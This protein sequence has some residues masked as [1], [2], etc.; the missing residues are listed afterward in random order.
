MDNLEAYLQPILHFF[1]N[2]P[3]LQ[4]GAVFLITFF[5]A[6][7]VSWIIFRVLKVLTSKTESYLDDRLLAIARP[8]IYYSLVITG[9]STAVKI[10]PIADSLSDKLIFG[11]KTI[12]VFIWMIALIRVSKIILQQLA[13]SNSKH[14]LVKPQTLPL[15]DNLSKVTIVAIAG[16]VIF[17][18]WGIDMTAWVASAGIV[19]LAV[20]FAA[21]DTLSNLFSG[22]FI[23]AD[24]PYKIG[25]Y[26]VLDGNQRGKVTHIGLRSTRL[27][28]RDDVEVTVPNSIMGNSKITNQ[29]GGP[30]PKFRIRVKIGV[31]YG[32]DI[33][34]VREILM[35]IALAEALV[36]KTPKPRVRFRVF[37][38]S[39]LDFELLCWIQDPELRGRTL[40]KL[41]V[42]IYNKFNKEKIEIPYSKQDLYIKELPK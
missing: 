12:G 19:G 36:T 38:A 17:Q 9:F 33:E 37:G 34:K 13:W 7:L 32:T 30:N 15:F 26:V 24:S 40:D 10:M 28:T 6:S 3:W 22:V 39:S 31:A 4:G 35:K 18:I 8:P 14:G 11:F 41:N 16:Y 21:K 20:S 42:A 23:L 29:S 25:D 1:G 2:Q 27:V 5:V